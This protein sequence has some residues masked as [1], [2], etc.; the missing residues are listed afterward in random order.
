MVPSSL[1]KL[2]TSYLVFQALADGKLTLTQNLPV[3]EKAWRMGGSKMFVPYPGSVSVEDLIRGMITQSGNDACIVL[4]EGI[5]GS[6]DQFVNRNER[7][8]P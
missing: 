8:R 1:T 7:G 3:S 2:M 4:A 5:S 6:E